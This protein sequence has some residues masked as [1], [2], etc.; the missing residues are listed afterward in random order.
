M[1]MTRN[2]AAISPSL[3]SKL[4]L[5][6][7]G[8][9][10]F[11]GGLFLT[12]FSLF[13]MGA[14][15]LLGL[16][17]TG[18]GIIASIGSAIGIIIPL[19]F[20]I[21]FVFFVILMVSL[22]KDP[23]DA[24]MAVYMKSS[25]GGLVLVF[26]GCF[27]LCALT[28]LGAF[29]VVMASLYSRG[30]IIFLAIAYFGVAGILFFLS[31]SYSLVREIAAN[32]DMATD[33]AWVKR[34]FRV[35]RVGGAGAGPEMDEKSNRILTRIERIAGSLLGMVMFFL[36]K[37]Q[38]IYEAGRSVTGRGSDSTWLG[39]LATIDSL[40]ALFSLFIFIF[41]TLFVIRSVKMVF[42]VKGSAVA[43]S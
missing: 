21:P 10:G 25:M 30:G 7:I 16:L 29:V 14:I 40:L 38:E 31:G 42:K 34:S 9:Y 15:S 27:A 35:L 13:L 3:Q 8:L 41:S 2:N 43:D 28:I 23:R 1:T 17:W 24:D 19:F 36:F 33:I 12:V 26:A 37:G 18:S 22:F 39:V 32:R 6:K 5:F 20:A 4:R 11:I